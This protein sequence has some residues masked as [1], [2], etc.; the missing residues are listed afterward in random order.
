MKVYL[1]LVRSCAFSASTAGARS[2]RVSRVSAFANALALLENDVSSIV[3]MCESSEILWA[4]LPT[5]PGSRRAQRSRIED[6]RRRRA[7]PA[8]VLDGEHGVIG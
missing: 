4:G 1:L 3:F 5:R 2:R 7:L 6:R 8:L